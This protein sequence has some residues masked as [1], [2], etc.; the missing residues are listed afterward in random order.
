MNEINDSSNSSIKEDTS[1]YYSSQELSPVRKQRHFN[2]PTRIGMTYYDP[3]TYIIYP[4]MLPLKDKS[5]QELTQNQIEYKKL[6][7]I[8]DIAIVILNIISFSVHYAWIMK[9]IKND[10]KPISSS[11]QY[12]Y[13][14]FVLSLIVIG[15]I[16]ARMLIHIKEKRVL[17]L[18]NIIFY[19]NIFKITIYR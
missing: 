14:T 7:T 18:I 13:S 3:Q 15:C 8:L 17:H 2:G 9:T 1:S 10:Y 5:I 19:C 11:N 6:I 16:I 4:F 12:L